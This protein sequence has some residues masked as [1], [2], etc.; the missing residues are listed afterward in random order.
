MWP[1]PGRGSPGARGHMRRAR[2]RTRD[3][4]W[5]LRGAPRPDRSAGMSSRAIDEQV[6]K[7]LADVHSIEV[8]AV[9]QM[10]RAP[11]IAGDPTLA[12]AF[13]EHLDE[14]HEHERLVRHMLSQRG[15]D[16]ST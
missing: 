9:A 4:G 8:Q 14:T 5:G 3:G 10:E 2:R 7:Y 16:T 6:T 1:W 11:D 13:A 15:A 12:Q